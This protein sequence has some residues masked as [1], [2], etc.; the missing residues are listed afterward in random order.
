MITVADELPSSSNI[1]QGKRRALRDGNIHFFVCC[2]QRR[3]WVLAEEPYFGTHS[4]AFVKEP[5][6]DVNDAASTFGLL[7]WASS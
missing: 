6:V 7:I 3:P 4:V 2:R 5:Y 1:V